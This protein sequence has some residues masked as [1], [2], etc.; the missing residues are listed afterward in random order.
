MRKRGA[1]WV[2][3][4]VEP[5]YDCT[6]DGAHRRP[7]GDGARTAI[8]DAPVGRK[9]GSGHRR[10]SG[11]WWSARAPRTAEPLVPGYGDLEEIGTGRTAVVYRAR[12]LETG[13]QVAL[14]V[15]EAGVDRAA[16][17]AFHREALALAALGNHPH[18]VT[19]YRTVDLPHGGPALVLELCDGSLADRLDDRH[20]LGPRRAT[21]TAVKVAGALETA[22]RAGILHLDVNPANILVTPYG[23]PALTDFGIARLRDTAGATGPTIAGLG[24]AGRGRHSGGGVLPSTSL[25]A[26]PE[27]LDGRPAGPATDV[28]QLAATLYQ[29]LAGRPPFAGIEGEG[30]AAVALRVLMEAPPPLPADVVPAALADLVR[31]AMAKDPADRPQ[32]AAAFA[33][34][35]RAVEL[36]CGWSPTA[37]AIPG[38][39]MPRLVTPPT[40]DHRPA[41]R[42]AGPEAARRTAPPG[43]AVRRP[44]PPGSEVRRTAPPAPAPLRNQPVRYP[45]PPPFGVPTFRLGPAPAAGE[46][47]GPHPVTPAATAAPMAGP[48]PEPGPEDTGPGP[49]TPASPEATGPDS[50]SPGEPTDPGPGSPDRAPL[51]HWSSAVAAGSAGDGEPPAAAPG[52]SARS[53]SAA[54][55]TTGL[56]AIA[57][58]ELDM[59]WYRRLLRGRRT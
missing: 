59:P 46:P 50:G 4:R 12:E 16:L 47:T 20:P 32:T 28:Y 40:G 49:G 23:E 37:P 39:L 41:A 58:P 44:A 34:A 13:R 52:T 9:R 18:I 3:E 36:T 5:A 22:H 17:D 43:S 8:G 45:V 6:V 7:T 21:A 25:H 57:M 53:A 24:A 33:D 51:G 31:W 35:L 38:G 29:L 10:R 48:E 27:L 26:A 30:G 1:G 14:K 15:I 56:E 54:R 19:L 2:W 42:A 55:T 11:S